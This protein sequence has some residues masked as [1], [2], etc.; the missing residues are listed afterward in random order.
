[1]SHDSLR[2]DQLITSLLS[3]SNNR[4]NRLRRNNLQKVGVPETTLRTCLKK[5]LCTRWREGTWYF[6]TLC[7]QNFTTLRSII[8][9]VKNIDVHKIAFLSDYSVKESKRKGMIFWCETPTLEPGNTL[10][11]DVPS[12]SESHSHGA[13]PFFIL[14]VTPMLFSLGRHKKWQ[15]KW[16]VKVTPR[17]AFQNPH[18]CLTNVMESR[19]WLG[20]SAA[21]HR[22]LG[23]SPWI[24]SLVLLFNCMHELL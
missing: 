17:G 4:K 23:H 3:K 11:Y 15:W 13:N 18:A 2:H 12:K 16:L 19:G 10:L 5:K 9:T 1:M 22:D 24:L 8:R 20:W 6:H 14:H 21:C 7:H